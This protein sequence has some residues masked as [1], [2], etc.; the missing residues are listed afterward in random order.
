[1]TGGGVLPPP[2]PLFTIDPR[3]FGRCPA[4][5]VCFAK[6]R[7]AELLASCS[8]VSPRGPSAA[9]VADRDRQ[10]AQPRSRASQRLL[11]SS[12]RRHPV[13]SLEAEGASGRSTGQIR[14][15][16]PCAPRTT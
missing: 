11:A 13:V 6:S 9:Q 10:G 4:F 14:A 1:M 8:R 2:L 15:Y 7:A 5:Q 12:D 16:L 3:N